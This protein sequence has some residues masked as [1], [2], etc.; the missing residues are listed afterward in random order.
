MAL[1]PKFWNAGD[2]FYSFSMMVEKADWF[3]GR[4]ILSSWFGGASFVR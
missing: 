1:F 3:R 4:A 2:R